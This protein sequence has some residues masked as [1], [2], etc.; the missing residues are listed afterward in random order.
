M[1]RRRPIFRL[2]SRP[3]SEEVVN[4]I[5]GDLTE[6]FHCFPDCV[7]FRLVHGCPRGV[8]YTKPH[9]E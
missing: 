9:R 8:E 7:Q 2:A 4:R 1:N 5:T 3:V 6:Q